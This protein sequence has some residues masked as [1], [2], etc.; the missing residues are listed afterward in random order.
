MRSEKE[1][2]VGQYFPYIKK[3]EDRRIY[4]SMNGLYKLLD[5][6]T[7]KILAEYNGV[8][9]NVIV[10]ARGGLLVG[11]PIC[12]E[13]KKYAEKKNT[14]PPELFPVVSRYYTAEGKTLEKPEF[15]GLDD[16]IESIQ[17][18]N[19]LIIDDVFDTGNTAHSLVEA[20]RDRKDL[21][22][23]TATPFYKPGRS[24][25]PDMEKFLIYLY[26]TN[27]WLVF[28][29]EKADFKAEE[30]PDVLK[31]KGQY[32]ILIEGK[33]TRYSEKELKSLENY[34]KAVL[35]F[36]FR[37]GQK[38]GSPDVVYFLMPDELSKDPDALLP[39]EICEMA[40]I[41][42]KLKGID[43]ENIVDFGVIVKDNGYKIIGP[44]PENKRIYIAT[45]RVP[46]DFN[47]KELNRVM[48]SRSAYGFTMLPHDKFNSYL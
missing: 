32:E 5:P 48:K 25:H 26:T 30:L 38:V 13:L 8:P 35:D 20:L 40:R 44:N 45:H 11:L 42:N 19:A 6:L 15:F 12:K 46:D 27:A 2:W 28:P 31:R 39:I 36:A 9:D 47:L 1:E 41:K 37:I 17:G 7:D 22:I 34:H 23:K 16:L 4:I 24:E 33:R 14:K 10:L 29:H 18:K 43:Q 21:E 3:E